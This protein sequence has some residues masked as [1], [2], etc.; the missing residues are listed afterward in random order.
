MFCDIGCFGNSYD[1]RVWKRESMEG[2]LLA[3]VVAG[4]MLS[5]IKK[6]N[7]NMFMVRNMVRVSEG[8]GGEGGGGRKERLKRDSTHVKCHQLELLDKEI[9][10]KLVAVAD[11]RTPPN[12]VS[13]TEAI[14]VGVPIIF[15]SNDSNNNKN[16]QGHRRQRTYASNAH[17]LRLS[18]TT[19]NQP[20][21]KSYKRMSMYHTINMLNSG[22]DRNTSSSIDQ[23]NS[24]PKEKQSVVATTLPRFSCCSLVL[25]VFWHRLL[26]EHDI[27]EIFFVNNRWYTRAHR[28]MVLVTRISAKFSV[29]GLFFLWCV[30]PFEK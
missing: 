26:H 12:F 2:A 6:K 8:E 27:L 17:A 7:L 5:K 24:V 1:N 25:F 11:E 13:R 4:K 18:A 28:T 19:L 20:W 21:Y 16:R 10:E 29:C 3:S 15:D 14:T 22:G 30:G 23:V 9:A